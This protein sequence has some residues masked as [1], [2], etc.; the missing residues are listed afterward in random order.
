MVFQIKMNNNS[1]STTKNSTSKDNKNVS[2]INNTIQINKS[3]FISVQPKPIVKETSMNNHTGHQHDRYPFKN[4]KFVSKY[5]FNSH[6]NIKSGMLNPI[7]LFTYNACIYF[8]FR[9]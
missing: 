8:Y 1:I 5:I 6:K 2:V 4:K 3:A 9:Y 7:D